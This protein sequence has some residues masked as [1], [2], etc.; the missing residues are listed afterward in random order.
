MRREGQFRRDQSRVGLLLGLFIGGILVVEAISLH[1]GV[2]RPKRE[3][4]EPLPAALPKVRIP[5]DDVMKAR[6]SLYLHKNPPEALIHSEE[7][8]R[9][10]RTADSYGV[11]GES[12]LQMSRH[13]TNNADHY[14]REAKRYLY[15]S[16]ITPG[17]PEAQSKSRELLEET[18]PP[19]EGAFLPSVP[20]PEKVDL[21]PRSRR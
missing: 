15:L 21:T 12:Y 1:Q 3:A 20:L 14:L 16:T 6:N 10:T 7:A 18:F 13:D 4:R 9:K 8:V 5:Y 2:R 19:L 11:L 17:D